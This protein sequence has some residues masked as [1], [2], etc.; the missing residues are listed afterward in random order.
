LI[1]FAPFLVIFLAAAASAFGEQ[2]VEHAM[3]ADSTCIVEKNASSFCFV[4]DFIG[5]R[6][7][8]DEFLFSKFYRMVTIHIFMAK[9]SV[10]IA[11]FLAL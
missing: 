6:H 5:G 1:G 11:V 4:S 3:A 8:F 10:F 9:M 7:R 2:P